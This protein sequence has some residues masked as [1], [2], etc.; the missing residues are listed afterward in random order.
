M[1]ITSTCNFQIQFLKALPFLTISLAGLADF[2]GRVHERR[3]CITHGTS[4]GAAP[5]LPCTLG[6]STSSP[7]ERV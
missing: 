7:D 2:P 6:T 3:A 1:Q 5:S 4:Y